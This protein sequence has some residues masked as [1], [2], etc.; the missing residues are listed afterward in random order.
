MYGVGCRVYGLGRV[1]DVGFQGL[2]SRALGCRVYVLG[3]G[4]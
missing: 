4:V 3:F 2:G 1:Y